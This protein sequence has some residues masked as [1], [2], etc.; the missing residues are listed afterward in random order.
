[1]NAP[2]TTAT[3]ARDRIPALRA[4]VAQAQAKL[5]RLREA[6]GFR[7]AKLNRLLAE[8]AMSGTSATARRDER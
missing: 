1:M 6:L 2:R 5:E 4:E 3:P 7:T 8:D